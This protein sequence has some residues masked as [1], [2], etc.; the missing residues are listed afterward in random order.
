VTSPVSAVLFA[1]HLA[2]VAEFYVEVFNA[3]VTHSDAEHVAL[4]FGGFDLLIHQIP[5]QFIDPTGLESPPTRRERTAIR[6]NFPVAD[7]AHARR[8]AARLGGVIDAL[9]PPWAGSDTRF[10]LGHD[11]E[12]N[13]FGAKSD[14]R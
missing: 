13:V 3:R 5:K 1:R 6:L 10:F 11:P 12:G 7:M 14:D 9:P 4:S 2:K 8:E